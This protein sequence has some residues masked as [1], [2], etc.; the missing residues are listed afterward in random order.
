MAATARTPA[1]CDLDERNLES[2]TFEKNSA[3]D[4]SSSSSS[5][6]ASGASGSN[7]DDWELAFASARDACRRCRA[8]IIARQRA[9]FD[10]FARTDCA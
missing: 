5:R 9:C 2:E 1:R 6:E 4:A 3:R 7:A 10:T 8:Y